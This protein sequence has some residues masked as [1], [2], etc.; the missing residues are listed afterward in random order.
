[1]AETYG[2][3]NLGFLT[4]TFADHVLSGREAQRRFNSLA[5]NVLRDRYEAHVR[6]IERQ[7]SGRLHY[8]L[9]VV[10]PFDARTGVDFNAFSSGDYR[11]ANSSLRAEWAFWRRTARAYRFGRTELMPVRSTEEGIGRYVGK[12]ISKHHSARKI[13]DRG[14]RLV[15]YSR[16]ARMARTRFGWCSDNAA[17]WRAKTR[18]FAQIMSSR[19]DVQIVDVAGLTQA[20]GPRW[21]YWHREFISSLP[22]ITAPAGYQYLASG[23]LLNLKTG[24]IVAGARTS[25]E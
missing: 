16:G 14:M 6:V 7:K 23:D 2:L 3:E 1:M 11:S 17:E 10:L 15:E 9:L 13:E 24:E 4:L 8:H 18:L 19:L 20:L 21:A 25:F 12:Y 22:V 5:S